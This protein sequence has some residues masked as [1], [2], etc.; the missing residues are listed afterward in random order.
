M[1]SLSDVMIKQLLDGRHIAC[2]GNTQLAASSGSKVVIEGI[3]KQCIYHARGADVNIALWNG[4]VLW[5]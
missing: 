1:A 5:A 2:F 4:Q 3:A